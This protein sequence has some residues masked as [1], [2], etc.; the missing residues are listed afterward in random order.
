MTILRALLTRFVPRGAILLSVL[1]FASY[2]IGLLRDRI[3]A[4]TFGAGHELDAYNAAFVLPELALDVLVASGLAAPFVPIFLQLRHDDEGAAVAFGQTILTGAVIVMGATAG[5]LFVLAPLTSSLITPGFDASQRELYVSL[6]RVMLVTPIIFAASIALGEVLVA[7]RRF[8]F[9][10]LAPPL[11]NG[12][13]I[14]GTVLLSGSLGIFGPAVG[15][16]IGA[17]L[18]LGIRLVGIRRT[19]FRVRPRLALR[20]RAVVEFLR[21]MIPKMAS[22]PIEPLTFLFFT[23]LATTLGAGSV[24]SVSFARNFQSVPVSLIGISFSLAAFPALAAAFVAGDRRRFTGIV[25]ANAVT[26][27]VLTIGAAIGLFL[28]ARIA[29]ELFLGGGAFD[30]ED[31]ARTSLVLSA[32]AVSVPFESLS[33]LLSRAIYATRNTLLP[34]GA[35]ICGFALTVAAGLWLAP[36]VGITAIPLAFALGSA[37]KL[38]LL[39]LALVPRIRLVGATAERPDLT[40][41]L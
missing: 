9:Y 31:I 6:F 26:I 23:S 21:L 29:I 18:H 5:V 14:L 32:F 39:A 16:V 33:H 25:A 28:V 24:S 8:L 15:A 40:E 2:V 12:G 36:Q 13:I 19:A 4:R 30:A 27:S 17:L 41:A 35:S 1:T 11:Y 38:G 37:L 22:H 3:F 7:Q 34:V 10:G 20:T